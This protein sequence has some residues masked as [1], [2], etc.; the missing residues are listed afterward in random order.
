MWEIVDFDTWVIVDSPGRCEFDDGNFKHSHLLYHEECSHNQ[1]CQYQSLQLLMEWKSNILYPLDHDFMNRNFLSNL[2]SY[3]Y[4]RIP[5]HRLYKTVS[6][7]TSTD[8]NYDTIANGYGFGCDDSSI[9]SPKTSDDEIIY[10][11]CNNDFVDD[12]QVGNDKVND[13]K[14]L[15]C[16]NVSVSGN[17]TT[18]MTEINV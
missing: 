12:H 8:S 1:N 18:T 15:E 9:N 13:E 7:T 2:K 11:S 16:A 6:D 14:C 10:K 17:Q 4:S 5:N 3:N